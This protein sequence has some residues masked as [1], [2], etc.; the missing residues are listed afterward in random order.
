MI[1]TAAVLMTACLSS[2]TVIVRVS[3]S[4][5]LHYIAIND[6]RNCATWRI[7]VDPYNTRVYERLGGDQI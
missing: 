4:V 6:E 2:S 7:V 1:Q 3:T 5:M